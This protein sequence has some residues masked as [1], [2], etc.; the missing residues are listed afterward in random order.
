M[1]T[2]AFLLIASP[3]PTP[4]ER[5]AHDLSRPSVA[6]AVVAVGPAP[7]CLAR[8]VTLADADSAAVRSL[9]ARLTPG[10]AVTTRFV[11]R[12]VGVDAR[13]RR[14]RAAVEID[15]SVVGHLAPPRV[16]T[17]LS[18]TVAAAPGLFIDVGGVVVP[19]RREVLIASSAGAEQDPEVADGL[20]VCARTD[21][22]RVLQGTMS[23]GT[24]RVSQTASP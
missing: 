20:S 14:C 11:A 2:F 19:C 13:G 17:S 1:F 21:T 16:G 5:L 7:G 8:R 3:A 18:I 9:A 6:V 10:E 22:G 24:L 12:A 4:L 23:E 15:V